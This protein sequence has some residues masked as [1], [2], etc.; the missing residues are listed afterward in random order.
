MYLVT[1]IRPNMKISSL[2]MFGFVFLI[3]I[4][5]LFWQL[6]YGDNNTK[7]FSLLSADSI[8]YMREINLFSNP[9]NVNEILGKYNGLEQSYHTS[10]KLGLSSYVATIF[11]FMKEI[12]LEISYFLMIATSIFLNFIK[13]NLL[14]KLLL[15]RLKIYF[16][17]FVI[18]IF[19]T[20]LYWSFRFLREIVVNDMLEIIFLYVIIHKPR[21]DMRLIAVL[22]VSL[23]IWRAQ[24]TLLILP[25][26]VICL[27][28]NLRSIIFLLVLVLLTMN[29]TLAASGIGGLAFIG[30]T[31]WLQT[32]IKAFQIELGREWLVLLLAISAIYGRHV[33]TTAWWRGYSTLQL[34]M[35]LYGL[36]FLLAFTLFT[37]IRFWYP[38][39]LVAKL[40]FA[41]WLVS[42]KRKLESSTK[43]N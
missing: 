21:I 2:K 35:L 19:P 8:R 29:Q 36:L 10:A 34:S 42:S 24:L 31:P 20:D 30:V 15:P 25:L 32:F 37:Q 23:L 33:D 5:I 14:N 43:S 41:I 18:V 9:I 1:R 26:L 28:L 16:L 38:T 27:S 22:S 12:S 4:V 6:F 39:F 13:I 11:F 17:F 3:Q 7:Y 40:T